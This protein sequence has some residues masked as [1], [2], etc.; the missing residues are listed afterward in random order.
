MIVPPLDLI[1]RATYMT[2]SIKK[3]SGQTRNRNSWLSKF[4][5]KVTL[6]NY[7]SLTALIMIVFR[8]INLEIFKQQK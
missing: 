8:A 2:E 5:S 3:E 7:F 4:L 6:A 1:S